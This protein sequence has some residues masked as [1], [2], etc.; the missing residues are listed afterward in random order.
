MRCSA[1]ILAV[2]RA[3]RAALENSGQNWTI[4]QKKEGRDPP[5]QPVK[6]YYSSHVSGQSTFGR[7]QSLFDDP[8]GFSFELGLEFS[9]QR[10]HLLKPA[11]LSSFDGHD[12][13]AS[14]E[15]GRFAKDSFCVC[16]A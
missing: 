1:F 8:Q 14:V 7:S 15:D 13:I 4:L 11:L 10:F 16:Q 3:C 9:E 5:G 12:E 2:A 6:F